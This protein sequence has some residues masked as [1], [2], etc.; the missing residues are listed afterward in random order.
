[1]ADGKLTS[2]I[3]GAVV[4]LVSVAA[5]H[6]YEHHE[7]KAHRVQGS[8]V[9]LPPEDYI[10]IEQLYGMYARD[11]DPGS[12]RPGSW[13]YT[14][15][16]VVALDGIAPLTKHEDIDKLYA[17]V[18]QA[19]S[20]G[21]RHF[22]TSYVIVGTPD[23]GARGSVYMLSLEKKSADGPVEIAHFGKYEDKLV[24]TPEGWRIKERVFKKDTFRGSS[25]PVTASPVPGNR[26][27]DTTGAEAI[28]AAQPAEQPPFQPPGAAPK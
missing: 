28:L 17:W 3:A 2:F 26:A 14:K 7:Y 4:A 16:A 1:M 11:A 13:M 18:R 20:A 19:Q 6:M 9:L 15:D 27:T 10:E 22:N 21:V 23:G 12:T 25:E 5:T 8:N 24:K